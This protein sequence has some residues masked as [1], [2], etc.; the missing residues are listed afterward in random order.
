MA[1]AILVV[2]N[3]AT[4]PHKNYVQKIISK[5]LKTLVDDGT[6][7]IDFTG[8]KQSG[9]NI[10]FTTLKYRRHKCLVL[11]GPF[12]S[13]F[14]VYVNIIRDVNYC[15]DISKCKTCTVRFRNRENELG[16]AIANTAMH[17][18]GHMFG[19]TSANSYASADKAGHTGN[20][21]NFMF[22]YPNHKD[23]APFNKDSK[24]TKLY[25]VKS[26]D[27]LWDICQTIG[28]V[29]PVGKWQDLYNLKGKDS[30]INRNRL[31]S[32]NPHKIY[33]NET[34]WVPDIQARVQWYRKVE[35][36]PKEFT[37]GQMNRMRKEI[38]DSKK[39]QSVIK[40]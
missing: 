29:P 1:E 2:N 37:A 27:T 7:T 32:K 5:G 38:K 30:T 18:I 16:A 33:P 3:L 8:K 28:F 12:G 34:I 10:T 13:N 6:L 14:S 15:D 40:F 4:T 35:G 19:L 36:T 20:E 39:P 24:R 23:Y 31:R 21:R 26:G 25:T 17:E 11:G 22:D 9:F